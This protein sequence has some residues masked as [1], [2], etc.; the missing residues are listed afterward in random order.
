MRA[1]VQ[2]LRFSLRS[3]A[4]RPSFALTAIL[5]LGVGLGSAAAVFTLLDSLL[6]RPLSIHEPDRVV[7]LA[8]RQES[9]RTLPF[10][11][12]MFDELRRS[13]ESV[14]GLFGTVT[15]A[16]TV[17]IDGAS[18]RAGALMVSGEFFQTLGVGPAL[19]RVLEPQDDAPGSRVVVLTHDFWV[20]RFG[21]DP[22]AVGKT[23]RLEWRPYT[24]VGVS[25]K[26]FTG[27]QPGVP[28][29]L[30]LPLSHISELRQGPDWDSA[31]L[32]W[33]GLYGRLAPGATLGQARAELQAR[34]PA[35]L[36][37]TAPADDYPAEL[38]RRF[39]ARKIDIE[40]AARGFSFYQSRF[41]QPLMVLAGVVGVLLTIVCVNIANLMLAQSMARQRETAIRLA[42]GAGRS[43]IF[44]QAV[45]ESVLLTVAGAALGALFS[46]WAV[47]GLMALWNNGPARV[48]LDL[49]LDLRVFAFLAAG[50]LAASLL[51]GLA[52][53][54]WTAL[55]AA[56]TPLRE[57]RSGGRRRLQG[58]LLATQIA[59]SMMLLTGAA[60]LATSLRNLR[61]QPVDFQTEGVALLSLAPVMG[62]YGEVDF[63]SYY[64]RLLAEV[65]ATPGI[66]AAALAQHHPTGIWPVPSDVKGEPGQSPDGLTATGACVSPELFA[67]LGSPLAAGR[68]FTPADGADA[69]TAAILNHTLAQGLFPGLDPIGRRVGFG[70]EANRRDLTVVGVVRD[71]GYRGFR[72]AQTAA[73]YVPC[74]Q[75]SGYR[76]G[77][78]T[79]FV[80]AA[81]SLT[82]VLPELRRRIE[83]LGVESPVRVATMREQAEQTLARER[84]VAWVASVFATMAM[85]LVAIG[86]YGML[87]FLVRSRTR[88][89]GV[90]MALGADRR[91]VLGWVVRKAVWL[92]LA[93]VLAGVPLAMAAAR[94]GESLLF[95]VEPGSLEIPLAAG[96]LLTLVSAAAALAPARRAAALQPTDA[97]RQE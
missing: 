22:D 33:I 67:T 52:P 15:P 28:C 55:G 80:R 92:A 57:T 21:A 30:I 45:F 44:R 1:I 46:I 47:R 72:D 71:S 6:W 2:D 65:R 96:L 4:R 86:L 25:A 91:R 69:P 49:R 94:Y 51:A 97:L 11:Q 53:A 56:L 79:L 37:A 20:R 76:R 93:G 83:S 90:R 54:I 48:A 23:F 82:A 87:S 29:E 10:S 16:V 68:A 59:F 18:E 19:G 5:M 13:V 40:S 24:I 39:F 9:A 60:L 73:V 26:G 84:T 3:L 41:E 8:V 62:G 89:I 64:D 63:D 35:I 95:Q 75:Q 58:V 70:P 61:S 12:P 34:W 32:L 36:E 38:R 43:R 31:R 27:M 50:T 88:E 66:E 85:A 42:V 81:G 74:A 78:L 14:E 7:R 77:N 17:E